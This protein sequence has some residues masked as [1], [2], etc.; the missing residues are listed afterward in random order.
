MVLEKTCGATSESNDGEV[1][2]PLQDQPTPVSTQGMGGRSSSAK[3]LGPLFKASLTEESNCMDG[4]VI[5]DLIKLVSMISVVCCSS[6]KDPGLQLSEALHKKFGFSKNLLFKCPKCCWNQEFSTSSYTKIDGKSRNNMEVNVQIIMAVREIGVG[7]EGLVDFATV[8]NM[9][10]PMT[11]KTYNNIVGKLNES[12]I[13]VASNSMKHAADEVKI[14]EGTAD[15]A[16][17]F[18]GSWQKPGHSSING[19][20]SAISVSTGKVLDYEVK[21]KKM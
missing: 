16:V 17:S 2:P 14:K 15:I 5:F 19:I 9:D 10:K 8:M 4:F 11:R 6:C 7:Y 3:K 21:S 18:D 13:E 20:V 1:R 12:F